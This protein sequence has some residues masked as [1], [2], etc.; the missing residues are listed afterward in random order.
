MGSEMCIR[1]SPRALR[2]GV[3]SA[4]V[5]GL[6]IGTVIGL[7]FGGWAWVF[8]LIAPIID[9][10]FA[11]FDH[12]HQGWRVTEHLII[13]RSGYLNRRTH[14]VSRKKIQS[15]TLR[16]G[17]ILR[18]WDLAKVVVRVAGSRVDLPLLATAEAR[19][20][21]DTLTPQARPVPADGLAATALSPH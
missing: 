13:A 15:I 5:E 14:V 4:I 17:P 9:V 20:L 8:L 12:R 1:D 11:W 2:R 19:H 7:W 10:L 16:Q 21:V 3:L 6:I 18:R